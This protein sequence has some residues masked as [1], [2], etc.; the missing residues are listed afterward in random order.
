MLL[1][2]QDKQGKYMTITSCPRF[3]RGQA[4]CKGGNP[5]KEESSQL[6][7]SSFSLDCYDLANSVLSH[8]QTALSNIQCLDFQAFLSQFIYMFFEN[9]FD[10]GAV[11]VL[12][13]ISA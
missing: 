3:S 12:G 8:V 1:N 9:G 10:E 13:V 11:H 6:L 2:L 4:S 7:F 5:M